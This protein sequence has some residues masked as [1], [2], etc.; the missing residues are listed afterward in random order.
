MGLYNFEHSLI[1]VETLTKSGQHMEVS[2]LGRK[3]D[4]K[5]SWELIFIE[6]KPRMAN[7]VHL[8]PHL[9]SC[10]DKNAIA[11]KLS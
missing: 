5:G 1:Q 7:R 3:G 10:I 4:R 2:Y 6:Y 11:S 9:D 8:H